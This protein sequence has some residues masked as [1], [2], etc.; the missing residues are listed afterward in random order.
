MNE[1]GTSNVPNCSKIV[2]SKGVKKVGKMTARKRGKSVIVIWATNAVGTYIPPMYIQ[3]V[4]ALIKNAPA[5]VLSYC[6][7][8]D[9]TDKKFFLK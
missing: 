7:E 4:D 6:T 8:S 1:T 2:A 5:G 9:G 3:K